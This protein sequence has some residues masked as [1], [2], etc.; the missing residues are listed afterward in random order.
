MFLEDLVS[1]P[2]P[3]SE[4]LGSLGLRESLKANF[5]LLE[6]LHSVLLIVV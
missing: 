1:I 3:P 6:N 4:F 5:L 2:F